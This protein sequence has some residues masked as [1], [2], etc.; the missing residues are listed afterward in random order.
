MMRLKLLIEV[1]AVLVARDDDMWVIVAFYL[2]HMTDTQFLGQFSSFQYCM[3]SRE[4]IALENPPDMMKC[5]YVDRSE[6][7]KIANR[8]KARQRAID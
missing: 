5:V 2:T 6:S 3:Q 7:L 1:M 8:D 4:T